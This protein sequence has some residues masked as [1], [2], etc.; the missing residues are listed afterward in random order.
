[1]R[2][3]PTVVEQILRD[4]AE[5]DPAARAYAVERGECNQAVAAAYVEEDVVRPYIAVIEDAVA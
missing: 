1:M 2:E 5:Y 4:I 3:H